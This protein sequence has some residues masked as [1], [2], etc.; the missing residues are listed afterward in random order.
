VQAFHISRRALWMA[1]EPQ[2]T[3]CP[4]VGWNVEEDRQKGNLTYRGQVIEYVS[5]QESLGRFATRT[6]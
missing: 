1:R 2:G 4:Q 5:N 3:A 6:A